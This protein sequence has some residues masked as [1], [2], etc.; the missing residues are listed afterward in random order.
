MRR[1]ANRL[2]ISRAKL[3]LGTIGRL[4]VLNWG[5]LVERH[6]PVLAKLEPARADATNGRLHAETLAARFVDRLRPAPC[7]VTYVRDRQVC[8]FLDVWGSRHRYRQRGICPNRR[9]AASIF[10]F[11]ARNRASF[12]ATIR[13]SS[14]SMV[15]G[16]LPTRVCFLDQFS[17][18]SR[19]LLDN[20]K[21][22]MP[23]HHVF[24]I[25]DLVARLNDEPG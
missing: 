22:L 2:E 11:A 12:S 14:G 4:A 18:T 15:S 6:R 25:F 21:R 19:S 16:S 8:S 1:S 23:L 9:R 24:D 3:G 7:A 20:V 5:G 17:S 13:A 10:S